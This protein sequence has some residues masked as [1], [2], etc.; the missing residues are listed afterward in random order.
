VLEH[1]PLDALE[2]VVPAA[3]KMISGADGRSI[4]AVDHVLA[5]WGSDSHLEGLRKIVELHGLSLADLDRTIDQLRDDPETYFVSAESHN[6]W[7]GGLPYDSYTMR[8]IV[9]VNID[10]GA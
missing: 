1:V 10:A 4:H 6:R 9:S 5:G 2:A 3:R 8:R 7:R